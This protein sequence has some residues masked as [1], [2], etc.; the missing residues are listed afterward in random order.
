MTTEAVKA[1]LGSGIPMGVTA[2]FQFSKIFAAELGIDFTQGLSTKINDLLNGDNTKTVIHATTLSVIPSLAARVQAGV[3]I[4]YARVGL[5]IGI[6]NR[7]YTV[8][9]GEVSSYK[10]TSTGE[11]RT[12]DYGGIALGIRAAGGVEVPLGKVVSLF[13]E[14]QARALSFSPKHG[15]VTKYSL[16]GVD[17]MPALTT[18]QKKWD[19]VKTVNFP[20]QISNDQPNQF[21]HVVHA[22]SNAA[23]VV[24]VKVNFGK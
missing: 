4:P 5:E 16:D 3:V 9:T 8:T 6:V 18:K 2:G 13:G 24:G 1:R 23:L 17:Q 14:I 11:K 10:A 22:V 21:L 19:Y 20:D 15:K 7:Y 12:L